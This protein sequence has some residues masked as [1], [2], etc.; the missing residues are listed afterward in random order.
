MSAV[1]K[2]IRIV[3]RHEREASDSPGLA[4]T[5]RQLRREMVEIVDSWILERREVAHSLSNYKDL[6]LLEAE[7]SG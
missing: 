6:M 4:K 2:S 1:I 3:K 5:E 7:S